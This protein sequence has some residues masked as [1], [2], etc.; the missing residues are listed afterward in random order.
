M[1][2]FHT[3]LLTWLLVLSPC[4]MVNAAVT[5]DTTNTPQA[6]ITVIIE[7]S[8][9]DMTLELEPNKAPLTVANFLKYVDDEY[10]NNTIFH[11]VIPYFMI[12]GGGFDQQMSKKQTRPSVANEASTDLPNLRGTIAMART[13]DPHSATSQFFIN[14]EDNRSLNKSARSAGYTVFGKVIKNM[15]LADRISEVKTGAH[16]SMRDVPIEQIIIKRIYRN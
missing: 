4:F 9:G 12:Q 11:R 6:A 10:Y 16:N 14:V 1:T 15:P 8:I 7:T 13:R 3:K 2:K 5:N